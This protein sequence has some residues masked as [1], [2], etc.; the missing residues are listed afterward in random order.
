MT[1][2]CSRAVTH[3]LQELVIPVFPQP[4]DAGDCTPRALESSVQGLIARSKYKP[5]AIHICKSAGELVRQGPGECLK[6]A[7]ASSVGC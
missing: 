3:F 7:L 5:L 1:A 2:N 6:R 4:R